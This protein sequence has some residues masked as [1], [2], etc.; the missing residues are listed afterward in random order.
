MPTE[1]INYD[2]ADEFRTPE[3]QAELLADAM[4]SRDAGYIAHALGI[5][6]RARGMGQLATDTG[7]KRQAL[8]R[9]LS[10]GGNPTL[11]TLVKVTDALGLQ[12]TIERRAA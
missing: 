8:Y 3:A 1:L 4:E 9:A 2:S 6:A 7:M 5:I 11:E 12:I 10:K